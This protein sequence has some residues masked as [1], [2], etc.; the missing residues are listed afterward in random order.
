MPALEVWV[1]GTPGVRVEP[2]AG[3]TRLG[4][5]G[6]DAAESAQLMGRQ[7][8]VP[9]FASPCPRGASRVIGVSPIKVVF[10]A[11]RN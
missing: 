1:L 5:N 11:G 6:T 4:A 8:R 2:L 3:A 7:G 9:A 10:S